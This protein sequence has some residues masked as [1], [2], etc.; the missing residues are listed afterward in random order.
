MSMRI[1]DQEH[2][3]DNCRKAHK[4]VMQ[5]GRLS[6]CRLCLECL[7]RAFVMMGAMS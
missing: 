2:H 6:P 5:F 3:C 1:V 7:A 4:P